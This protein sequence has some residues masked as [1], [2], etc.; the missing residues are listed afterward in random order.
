MSYTLGVSVSPICQGVIISL[1]HWAHARISRCGSRLVCGVLFI[2]VV[3]YLLLCL[4]WLLHN[5][6]I[7]C[8]NE[9][10]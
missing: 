3:S 9:I 8:N 2:V 1:I 6:L 5:D 10:T 4:S 7:R